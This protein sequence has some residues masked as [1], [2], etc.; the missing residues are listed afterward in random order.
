MG[1]AMLLRG[2]TV[3]ST[4]FTLLKGEGYE[5]RLIKK[6]C[7][8]LGAASLI[9]RIVF[10]PVEESTRLFFSNTLGGKE[11][12]L[13]DRDLDT[14]NATGMSETT[15]TV[16]TNGTTGTTSNEADKR[17]IKNTKASITNPAAPSSRPRQIYILLIRTS[18]LLLLLCPA[19]IPPILPYLLPIILPPRYLS[20]SAPSTLLAYLTIYIPILALNGILEAVFSV[21]ASS[22]AV[23]NQGGMMVLCSGV[24]GLALLGMAKGR[25]I[26]WIS[27]TA[28]S[29]LVAANALQM[30]IRIIYAW[31]HTR[32]V[33][34]EGRVRVGEVLPG[35]KTVS[36]VGIAGLGLRV[37]VGKVGTGGLG[38]VIKVV[39][40]GG[41]M[42]VG[43]LSI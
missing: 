38:E 17:F 36:A 14:T 12:G 37:F 16:E 43:C 5:E 4:F 32:K 29:C 8:G 3:G 13:R 33:F 21:T 28:E 18:L 40:R 6:E 26:G 22:G 11:D 35:W 31:A 24:F 30:I 7:F 15:R 34:A 20:T 41:V 39:V 23:V 19:F 1:Q 2:T 42:G 9:A 27:Y 10:Q 25:D